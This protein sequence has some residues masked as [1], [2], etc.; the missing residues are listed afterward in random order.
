[1]PPHRTTIAAAQ[2]A[3]GADPISTGLRLHLSTLL[4]DAGQAGD[5]LPHIEAV[6]AGDPRNVEAL[7]Q[8]TRACEALGDAMRAKRFREQATTLSVAA[9]PAVDPAPPLPGP[10]SSRFTL[11]DVGGRDHLKQRLQVS[12]LGPLRDPDRREARGASGRGGLMF[13]GPPGCGK[14]VLAQAL[15]GELKAHFIRVRVPEITGAEPG[16]PI[17]LSSIFELARRNSPAIVFL[18]DIEAADQ[19]AVEPLS[20]PL[21]AEMAREENGAVFVV[22]ATDQPWNVPPALFER[23]GFD[24]QMLILPPDRAARVAVLR[25]HLR[26]RQ[27]D[28]LNLEVAADDLDG[29]SGTDI[30]RV[31]EEA[32]QAAQASTPARLITREDLEE[33]RRVVPRSTPSWFEAARSHEVFGAMHDDLLVYMRSRHIG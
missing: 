24:R 16:S 29:Y 31:C 25:H 1:M 13:C 20:A 19:S 32:A 23:G 9:G 18:D 7:L 30:A 12:F 14:S 26:G 27:A 21:L 4:L 33:A 28:S 22:A 10:V 5:A 2:A 6:L 17:H 8:A 11:A 3:V 15:A